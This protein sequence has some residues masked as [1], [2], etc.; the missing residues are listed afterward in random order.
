LPRL[1]IRFAAMFSQ[2]VS[3]VFAEFVL[4]PWLSRDPDNLKWIR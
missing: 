3:Y 1:G 2:R 4:V